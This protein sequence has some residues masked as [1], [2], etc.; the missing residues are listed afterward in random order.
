MFLLLPALLVLAAGCGTTDYV[1]YRVA[2]PSQ[3]SSL[4]RGSSSSHR[5]PS[6]A[7]KPEVVEG[8]MTY[9]GGPKTIIHEVGPLE[10]V[11]RI[12]RM[13]GVSTEAIRL[14]NGLDSK[15]ALK[16][17]QKLTI[18]NARML[19]HV[20]NLYRNNQWR[21]IVVH[22]TATWK[23]NARAIN[24]SHGD[25]GFWN[26]LGYHFLI[27]NGTMGKGDGQ[28]EMS[29]RWIRQQVGAHCKAG[30]MNDKSIG[31]ALV[32]N[33]N[34][35]SPTPNQIQALNY[36]L[37]TLCAYYKIPATNIFAH[38]EVEGAKTECPGNRFPLNSIR[39]SVSK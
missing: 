6:H 21:H 28:I 7:G 32:G 19:R 12:G 9:L 16:I 34:T 30:G 13:Y 10:S 35:D 1:P 26:G 24:V 37:K 31:V 3:P 8:S 39:Q 5:S 29:P 2:P 36:L 18:P 15:C 38:R 25:R 17:G 33:F 11:W 20:I 23:G 27:D 4:Q 14:A 22:H